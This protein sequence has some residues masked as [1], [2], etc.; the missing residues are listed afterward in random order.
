MPIK[1]WIK[2]ARLRTLPL[3]IAG[4]ISGNLM[5]LAEKKS[6]HI[7]IFILSVLTAVALQVLSNYANDYGDFK[8]GA[9]TSERKDRVMANGEISEIAMAKGIKYLVIICLILGTTLLTVSIKNIG[10]SSIFLFLFGILGIAAAYFYTAGKKPYGYIGLGDLAVF[11]FF[12]YLAVMGT[13]FLQ[14]STLNSHIWWVASAIG[15]LSV[16]VLNVN[17]IRDI[18]T[19]KLKNKITIP[20]NIGH[21]NAIKYH[22]FLMASACICFLVYVYYQYNHP[23]QM[24]FL[25]ILPLFLK[26]IMALRK[27]KKEERIS[28]NMQLKKLSI[29]TLFVSLIFSISQIYFS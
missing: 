22:V 26:H 17:N 21:N 23:L 19:D 24:S 27:A 18:E 6:L 29:L 20:V 13:Y 11:L 25:L 4:A 16:G 28:Y 1:V 10:V 15:L 7:T 2:A 3:A 14:T 12:G 5:A 8:N 9:D